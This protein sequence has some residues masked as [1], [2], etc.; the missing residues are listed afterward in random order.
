MLKS[1][2]HTG[3]VVRDRESS[4]AFYTEVMGLKLLYEMEMEGEYIEKVVGFKGAHIKTAHLN[5]GGDHNL[6]I[7]QYVS[8]PSA[9]V[10][11]NRNDLGATHLAFYVDDLDQY[12]ETMRHK[13]LK[14]VGPPAHRIED[15][16]VVRKVSYAQDP[17][18][19]WLEFVEVSN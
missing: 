18:G 15:G 3:V 16:K 17:D 5:M 10:Q 7:V 4:V 2:Y 11:V 8:P 19:N 13:G 9:E 14:F 1:I 6:E 12:Y